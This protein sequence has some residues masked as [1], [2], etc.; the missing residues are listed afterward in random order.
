MKVFSRLKYIFV[1]S[2][3][4]FI[5]GSS[6][7]YAKANKNKQMEIELEKYMVESND[8]KRYFDI[9]KA[10]S[11]KASDDILEM[12]N[13]IN[14]MAKDWYNKDSKRINSIDIK[15]YPI[16]EIFENLG[17]KVIWRN[18]SREIELYFK[19]E[20]KY[21]FYENKFNTQYKI[22]DNVAYTSIEILDAL[23][24][25]MNEKVKNKIIFVNK[26][27]LVPNFAYIK[28]GK[29]KE[30]DGDYI[31]IFWADWCSKCGS[32]TKALENQNLKNQ[33]IVLVNLGKEEFF[34]KYFLSLNDS[35]ETLF[36]SFK[37]EY[38]PT[39]FKIEKGVIKEKIIGGNDV[40]KFIKG[41]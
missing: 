29:F 30:V 36:K 39:L 25:D 14:S 28:D 24:L 1:V 37:G 8:G 13:L 38:V 22:V 11:E 34:N 23:D 27:R 19:E 9:D 33:K 21:K 10:K 6:C 40:V 26:E 18:D 41:I 7:I 31:I 3:A 4:V 5:I 17:Y 15:K 32:V 12:G 16:R 20:L 35:E 2:M